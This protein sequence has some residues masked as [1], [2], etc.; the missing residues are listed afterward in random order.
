MFLEALGFWD[1][2]VHSPAKGKEDREARSTR[3]TSARPDSKLSGGGCAGR[4]TCPSSSD[5]KATREPGV[6]GLDGHGWIRSKP[7]QIPAAVE[8]AE[9]KNCTK[10]KKQD[11]ET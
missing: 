3:M 8:L 4:K 1:L 11:F 7:P 10:K 9:L 6:G 5:V 2:I